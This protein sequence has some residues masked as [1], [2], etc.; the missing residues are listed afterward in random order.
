M[1]NI[2][3]KVFDN[4]NDELKAKWDELYNPGAAYNLS[5]DWC[6]LWWENFCEYRKLSIIAIYDKRDDIKLIAPFYKNKNVLSLIGTR[7]LYFDECNILY[8]DKE[9]IPVLLDYIFENKLDINLEHVNARTDFA[10]ILTRYLCDKK[11]RHQA[12]VSETKQIINTEFNPKHGELKNI[13]R[14]K[15]YVENNL[16]DSVV[17]EYDV[18]KN[19]K[20]INEFIE[21]HKSRWGLFNRKDNTQ[22][23]FEDLM[24]N[25]E[26]VKLSRLSLKN[27][28]ITIA[29]ELGIID[30]GGKY[31][32]LMSAYDRNY[33]KISPGKVLMY[34][35]TKYLLENSVLELDL[36]RGCEE[37]KGG[38]SNEENVLLF[39][40]SQ[41]FNS[42]ANVYVQIVNLFDKIVKHLRGTY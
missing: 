27:D 14:Q 25:F 9:F 21:L 19:S 36:G 22:K 32:F 4:F 7:P 24:R 15:R 37:Y 26:N 28:D 23:Y 5:F 6:R 3:I 30:S 16:Q 41:Q 1:A 13:N 29:Y 17:F 40:N 12:L 31:W 33:N 38:Y 20:V 34:E 11:I 18:N 42:I 2:V 8:K 10:N 35:L 39:F